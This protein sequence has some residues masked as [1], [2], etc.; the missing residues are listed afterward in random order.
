MAPTTKPAVRAAERAA[1]S[2]VWR[3]AMTPTMTTTTASRRG[4]MG[5]FLGLGTA[6]KVTLVE[7][8]GASG[9]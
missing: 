7:P 1:G 6:G 9:G 5:L 3:D 2:L 4:H 8:V